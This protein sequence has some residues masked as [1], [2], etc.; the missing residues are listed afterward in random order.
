MEIQLVVHGRQDLTA[1]I[2]RQLRAAIVDG[3]LAA[4]ARLPSTRDLAAQLGVSRK[5]TLEAYE[6]LGAE[7]FLAS[8]RG[9]GTF[10]AEGVTRLP[11]A[12]TLPT[13]R[14]A[15]APIWDSLPDAL[16]R[17]DAALQFDFMGGVTD[18]RLFPFDAPGGRSAGVPRMSPGGSSASAGVGRCQW[19]KRTEPGLAWL[20]YSGEGPPRPAGA[21]MKTPFLVRR[22]KSSWDDLSLPDRDR[23]LADRG[24]RDVARMSQ[25]LA[26]RHAGLDHV[27]PGG[28]RP[29]SGAGHRKEARLQAQGHRRE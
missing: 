11:A 10:V 29:R 8:R 24:K 22:A 4:G 26:D 14:A 28:A 19:Q 2:Y 6:Q 5:T 13:P 18:K 16:P 25:R 20:S 23:P 15:P 12:P 17:Q 27:E 1:Q 9:D 21:A 3:R 7:G